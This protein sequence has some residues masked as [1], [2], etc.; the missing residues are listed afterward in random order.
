MSFLP[1]SW[2]RGRQT[3]AAL[4]AASTRALRN[5]TRRNRTPVASKIAVA[6]AAI[7]DLHAASPGRVRQPAASDRIAVDD[8]SVDS[9]R[10]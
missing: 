10:R 4:S 2:L 5:G 1:H 8:D 3:D 9:F 6:T 7:I